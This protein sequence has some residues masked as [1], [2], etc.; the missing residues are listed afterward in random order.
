MAQ[1][2]YTDPE[3]FVTERGQRLQQLQLAYDTY[4]TFVPGKSKVVWICHALTASSDAAGWWP[5][6]VGE[7][8][9]INPD[10]YFIICVNLPSSCYGSSGPHSINPETGEPYYNTFPWFTVRDIVHAFIRLREALHIE[11]I[12][13]L[14]GGSMGGYQCLE[15][16]LAEPERIGSLMLIATS[17][18]ESAW[19]IAIHSAQRLAIESD[20][21]F[22]EKTKSAG[23]RGLKTARA[24]GM[25]TYRSYQAFNDTQSDNDER[26][27][28]FR[29]ESYINYQGD[30]LVNRFNAYS[31]WMLTK[32]MDSHNIGRGR[33]G[34]EAALAQIRCRTLVIGITT[35]FLC[36][37]A[38][39]EFLAEHIPGAVLEIIES[40]FGHDGFLVEGKKAGEL[41]Q[42]H[43][44]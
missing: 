38:E 26:I 31:Y 41:L 1:Q 44:L 23:A 5:E 21:S 15:W 22:G 20:P 10:D 6:L 4:G 19:G 14:M 40:P 3:P 30:K 7:G 13:L 29:A 8:N 9:V 27:D 18:R 36:P 2:L 24:I 39:Q 33:G 32:T 43:L 12:D 35:D 34:V 16:A 25:L 17:A 37:N 42:R 11:K 28:D